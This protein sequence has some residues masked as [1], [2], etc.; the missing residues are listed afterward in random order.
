MNTYELAEELEARLNAMNTSEDVRVFQYAAQMLRTQEQKIRALYHAA[1]T[2][3]AP[4]KRKWIALTLND[5]SG[6]M[7]DCANDDGHYQ[8]SCFIDFAKEIENKI[9]ELNQ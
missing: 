9:K 7:C 2:K 3:Q 8:F 1:E 4:V 6:A 5:I